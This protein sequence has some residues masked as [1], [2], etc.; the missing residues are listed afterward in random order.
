MIYFFIWKNSEKNFGKSL[1]EQ[2]MI[3]KLKTEKNVNGGRFSLHYDR[4]VLR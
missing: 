3:T 4:F 1:E 2:N